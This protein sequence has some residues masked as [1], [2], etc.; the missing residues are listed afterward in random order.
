MGED[1][2]PYKQERIN[3]ISRILGLTN[4]R[5]CN[6]PCE[7]CEGKMTCYRSTAKDDNTLFI[8]GLFYRKM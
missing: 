2:Y 5:D 6:T 3:F 1:D 4:A 7:L 8:N